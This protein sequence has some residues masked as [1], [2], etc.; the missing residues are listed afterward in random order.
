[1]NLLELG[2]SIKGLRKEKKL[3]QVDLAKDVGIS[4]TTL[5]KLE[6]GYLSQIS[7]VVLNDVLNHLGYELDIQVLNPF[8]TKSGV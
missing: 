5:S 6:N 1:M 2:I 3:T 8:V 7:I 4:R